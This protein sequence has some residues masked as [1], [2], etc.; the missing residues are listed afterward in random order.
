MMKYSL[1]DS[2]R[3]ALRLL[4]DIQNDP[5]V[6]AQMEMVD[7][8]EG[9]PTMARIIGVSGPRSGLADG[10]APRSLT[11]VDAQGNP[12][13]ELIL[14]LEGGVVESIEQTWYSTA[15]PVSIPGVESVT[16]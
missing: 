16:T 14:W 4:A 10:V 1:T 15:P 3:L 8:V 11:V 6:S 7:A 9:T 13:G 5:S 12:V 2:Q